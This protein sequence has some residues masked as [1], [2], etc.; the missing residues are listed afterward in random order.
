[1]KSEMK[2]T[3]DIEASLRALE[4]ALDVKITIVDRYGK[5]HFENGEPVLGRLWQSH[6]KNEVCR[7]GF[8]HDCVMHC[9]HGMNKEGERLGKPFVHK[10]WKGVSELVIPLMISGMHCGSLFAGAWR[11]DERPGKGAASLP[12]GFFRAWESLP[13]IKTADVK[14]LGNILAVYARGMLELLAGGDPS[15]RMIVN[16]RILIRDF[17]YAGASGKL[18]L[19]KLAGRLHLSISRTSHLVK[20]IFGKSFQE[21]LLDE[22]VNRAKTLL[23]STDCT[24]KEIS[25][26]AGFSDEYYFNRTFRR[27]CGTTPGRYR[28]Q[29]QVN[30]H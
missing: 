25:G 16:R 3:G 2:K 30:I 5:F 29:L 20:S 22:R 13:L 23:L 4:K 15:G 21:L 8:R 11:D 26:L 19:E 9:R 6:Q 27:H 28:R 1:M 7:I 24:S 17:I 14:M 12:F 18:M 10:C